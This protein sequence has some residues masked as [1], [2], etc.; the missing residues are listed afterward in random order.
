MKAISYSLWGSN[1][2]YLIGAIRNA[3]YIKANLPDWQMVVWY[4]SDVLVHHEHILDDLRELGVKLCFRPQRILGSSIT[5]YGCFWRFR[6]I[7]TRQYSHVIFRDCDSRL[8]RRDMAA[9]DQWIESD[10][11]L[12]IIRDHP[13][14]AEA[15]PMKEPAILGG[16]WG[17]NCKHVNFS[18][19]Y[20][21]ANYYAARNY[22]E[23]GYG[24]DQEFLKPIMIM[25]KHSTMIHDEVCGTGLKFPLPR[26][27]WAFAGE[28]IGEDEMPTH[29]DRRSLQEHLRYPK[30]DFL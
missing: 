25:F 11:A 19:E 26:E 20:M 2:V 15:Y 28:R 8:S 23:S 18:I 6:T 14:H 10:L 1:P 13:Y 7:D 30:K 9:V 22:R 27:G 3:E 29:N 4:G 21:I 24:S 5:E 17:I 16:L 12:H